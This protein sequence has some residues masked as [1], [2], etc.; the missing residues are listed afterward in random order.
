MRV[1]KI[2]LKI[3]ALSWLVVIFYFAGYLIG[4]K[5]LVFEKDYR[6]KLV[7]LEL[8]KPREVDFGLFWKAW[9]IVE[10]KYVGEFL[11]QKLVYGAIKGMVEAL[12]DPYSSFLAPEDN[13]RFLEDLSGGIEGIGAEL[14][15]EEGKIVV[16]APLEESPA[17]RAGLK[18]RDIIL[19][20]NDEDTSAMPLEQ[21]IDK[22]R[23]P[24]GTEVKLLIN[25]SDFT[26]PQEF[27]I[28][29]EKI[30][31]A[32][33]KW[34]MRGNIG[35]IKIT[36][37]GEDTSELTQK[38]ATEIAAKNPRAV[39]LDLRNNPGGYLDSSIDVASL[40]VSEG[41][42]IVKEQYKDG[43]IEELKT[44]L[45]P[46][47]ADEKIIV[48]INEGSAS[49]AE[50]VAG[51]LRDLRGAILI[52]KATFGKGTVQELAD[53]DSASFLRITVAKWLTP[54]G[55][56]IDQEGIKPEIEVDRTEADIAAGRDPQLDKALDLG[57][58]F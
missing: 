7:N 57:N 38:A 51:A 28:R 31:I 19:Q 53:L 43:H 35:L 1:F 2:A 33:V 22:I 12:D 17:M 55:K 49:A 9:E 26:V 21:A 10:Q 25:R 44:T 48:L 34:E 32:S 50:I 30:V 27:K 13:K 45:K 29:R 39:I 4:H 18:A 54:Q 23:G 8:K 41:Q 24:A 6:P 52:G 37:F 11:P 58:N 20:V 36:Q 16:V 56:V 47:L 40:F 5:N 46:K 15:E 42:V 3:I 14:A